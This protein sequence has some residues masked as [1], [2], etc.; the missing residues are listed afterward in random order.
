MQKGFIFPSLYIYLGLGLIVLTLGIAVKVQSARLEACKAEH[1]AFVSETER[2]GKEAQLKVKQVEQENKLKK[3][4]ADESLRK[5]R[6]ANDDLTK[7]VR[8]NT[9]GNFVSSGETSTG[10]PDLACFQTE[11]LD[12]SIR[13]FASG[14]SGIIEQG[15]SAVTDLNVSKEWAQG[16]PDTRR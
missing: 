2:L 8:E 3:E 7:R 9:R 10:K 12:E 4:K 6:I 13:N 1:Q 16:N 15:Q 11:A 5:L 14:V